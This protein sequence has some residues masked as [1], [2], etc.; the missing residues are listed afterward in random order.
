MAKVPVSVVVIAKNEEDNIEE[1]LRSVYGWADELILVDDQSS[2][3]TVEIAE[4]IADK[5][6]HRKMSNEGEHRN[7]AIQQARNEWVLSLDADEQVTPELRNEITGLITSNEF[8]AFS[9]PL[10]TYIGSYWVKHSGWYPA[11]KLR[12]YMKSK[13]RFEEVSVHPRI[14]LDGKEK[15]LSCDIIHKG[16]PDFEHFLGS[17]NRQTTLEA[18]KWI[19]GGRKM[20]LGVAMWRT[21]DRLPRVFFGKKG[22]KDGFMGFMIA[23]FASLYQIMSYAKYWQ[24]NKENIKK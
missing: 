3:K 1:C 18:Q 17:L 7:W 16:Y 13:M 11:N 22:Y 9:I 6:F 5:I 21:I 4:K 14:F 8:Q 10:K 15:K 23:F 12:M 24:I 20:S 19:S 2:D